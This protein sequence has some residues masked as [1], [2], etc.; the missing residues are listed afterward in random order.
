MGTFIIG[1]NL[2]I[3][4]H[5]LGHGLAVLIDGGQIQEYYLNPFSWSWN[6]G[7]NVNNPIFTAWGG[8]TFGLI[9]P[10]IPIIFLKKTRS[11]LVKTTIIITAGCAFLINGIYLLIGIFLKIGDGGELLQYGTPPVLIGLLG[12]LYLTISFIIWIWVQPWLDL[13]K[14][15]SF[16]RRL[17]IFLGGLGPYMILILIYNYL[18]NKTQLTIWASFAI[19]GVILSILFAIFGHFLAPGQASSSSASQNPTRKSVVQLNCI[20]LLIIIGEFIIFG[21]KANPF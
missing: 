11:W 15:S 21:I 14:D 3:A 9:I 4:F 1:Y 19:V 8:V 18:F 7:K 16:I 20:A 13:K 6:L 10:L 12:F 17:Y 2:T 5:E